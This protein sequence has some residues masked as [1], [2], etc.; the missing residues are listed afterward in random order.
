MTSMRRPA[1]LALPLIELQYECLS[2]V[3][4]VGCEVAFAQIWAVRPP[5][6]ERAAESNV[7]VTTAARNKTTVR[8]RR[9]PSHPAQGTG[10]TAN[11]VAAEE[12][13][14]PQIVSA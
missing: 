5:L 3:P 13:R 11:G 8:Y 2:T 4:M 1:S 9:P 12:G 10:V 7:A 14:L 6:C